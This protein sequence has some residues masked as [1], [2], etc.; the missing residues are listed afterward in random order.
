MRSII[1]TVVDCLGL[2]DDLTASSTTITHNVNAVASNAITAIL[3]AEMGGHD[4]EKKLDEILGKLGWTENIAKAVLGGLVNALNEG[5][6]MGQAM[7]KAFNKATTEAIGFVREHPVFCTV[8]ALGILVL[9]APW[10]L[11]ALGFAELGPVED[12]PTF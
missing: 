6:P 4:L 12:E 3:G 9:L 1:A 11:E 2:Q 10:V 8:V 5:A 7:K